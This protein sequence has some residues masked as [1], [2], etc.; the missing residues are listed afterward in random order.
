MLSCVLGT[1]RITVEREE[2]VFAQKPCTLVEQAYRHPCMVKMTNYTVIKDNANA[3]FGAQS[4]WSLRVHF[5]L[6]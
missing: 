1:V 6:W 5:S 2:T 4:S 3:W